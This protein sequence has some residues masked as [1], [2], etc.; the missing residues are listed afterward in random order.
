MVR[1]RRPCAEMYLNDWLLNMGHA[2]PP[3]VQPD[4]DYRQPLFR[5]K[6]RHDAE[7]HQYNWYPI[8]FYD[9]R[10]GENRDNTWR[11]R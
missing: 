9:A 10:E 8:N 11:R 7:P 3:E 6:P 4:T 5:S 1:Q 2:L